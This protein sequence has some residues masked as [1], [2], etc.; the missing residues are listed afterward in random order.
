MIVNC[1]RTIR[2]RHMVASDEADGYNCGSLGTLT[3]LW[4]ACGVE[5]RL[6]GSQPLTALSCPAECSMLSG[7]PLIAGRSTNTAHSI[8]TILFLWCFSVFN[9]RA[10]FCDGI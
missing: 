9:N 2:D 4:R 10:H 7:Q 3:Q 1:L 6:I 5:E 8:F